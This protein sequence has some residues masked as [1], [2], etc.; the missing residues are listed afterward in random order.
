MYTDLYFLCDRSPELM[1][2][3]SRGNGMK[4]GSRYKLNPNRSEGGILCDKLSALSKFPC[5]I[6]IS[7]NCLNGTVKSVNFQL[8]I[9]A[10]HEFVHVKGEPSK[11]LWKIS[12]VNFVHSI[13]FVDGSCG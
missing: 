10:S 13:E 8:F 3:C 12:A 2:L 7:S 11:Y 4:M 9:Q 5:A 6:D 1:S